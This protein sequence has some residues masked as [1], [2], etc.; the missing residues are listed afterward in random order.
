MIGDP[1]AVLP[2]LVAG[3][4]TEVDVRFGEFRRNLADDRRAEVHHSLAAEVAGAGTAAR[5][6]MDDVMAGTLVEHARQ[7]DLAGI[8]LGQA[9]RV[10]IDDVACAAV[11][12]G[13]DVERIEAALAVDDMA[14][15]A[16]AE[17]PLAERRVTENAHRG[18]AVLP[19]RPLLPVH[20][21]GEL[22]RKLI[23]LDEGEGRASVDR[24]DLQ[25]VI[26]AH[27]RPFARA[28]DRGDPEVPVARLI[29]TRE[30]DILVERGAGG[31]PEML[32][33]RKLR[34]QIDA[35]LVLAGIANR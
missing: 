19:R 1:A 32:T 25:A 4:R 6:Q 9:R 29:T 3:L 21:V 5:G 18:E 15:C 7:A 33:N 16:A 28:P 12:M 17:A 10:D 11:G 30:V 31:D 13:V 20:A 24:R 34:V 27:L 35:V 2:G 26:G 8:L 14:E 22:R 23:P